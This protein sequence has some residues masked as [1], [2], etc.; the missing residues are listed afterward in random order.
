MKNTLNVGDKVRY[1]PFTDAPEEV[2]E[3]GIVKSLCDDHNWVFVVYNCAGE[4][5]NYK[6]YTAARTKVEQL[7][8]GWASQ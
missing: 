4:W 8:P 7:I 5:D 6:N 3:K 2:W 1:I